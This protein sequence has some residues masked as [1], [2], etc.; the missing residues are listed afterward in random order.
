MCTEIVLT[1][2]QVHMG[3]FWVSQNRI[4][5]RKWLTLLGHLAFF[6]QPNGWGTTVST[7]FT[8][9]STGSPLNSNRGYPGFRGIPASGVSR[10]PGYSGRSSVRQPRL[11]R[12]HLGRTSAGNS[13][14]TCRGRGLLA[15]FV[16]NQIQKNPGGTLRVWSP[17]APSKL[18]RLGART[19]YAPLRSAHIR[20]PPD[21]LR[22]NPPGSF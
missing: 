20:R 8:R 4:K 14:P 12:F 16:K 5:A 11:P 21:V 13:S 3:Q 7:H 10:L 15:D 22:R 18:R 17:R 6:R 19:L 2:S 1:H 9:L